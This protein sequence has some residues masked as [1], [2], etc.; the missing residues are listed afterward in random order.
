MDG[1]TRGEV[2]P[3]PAGLRLEVQRYRPKEVIGWLDRNHPARD[4]ALAP[5]VMPPLAMTEASDSPNGEAETTQWQREPVIV[6]MKKYY[7]PNGVRPKGTSIRMVTERINR[8]PEFRDKN[9]SEDTVL[10]ADKKIKAD[11]RKK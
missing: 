11:L 2:N 10:R 8:E 7:P 9:V 1:I 3:M 5:A 6:V 4:P